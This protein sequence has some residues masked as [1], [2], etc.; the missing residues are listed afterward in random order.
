MLSRI[1]STR[2]HTANAT[3]TAM[4]L[5]GKFLLQRHRHLPRSCGGSFPTIVAASS[6]RAASD[7]AS[8]PLQAI[9]EMRV[10][11]AGFPVR[12][13]RIGCSD[14]A[15][16]PQRSTASA[17]S[18]LGIVRRSTRPPRRSDPADDCPAR[19]IAGRKA[20]FQAFVDLALAGLGLR[21]LRLSPPARRH[22][23]F[24]PLPCRGAWHRVTG[25]GS[26]GAATA[27]IQPRGWSG[28]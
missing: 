24:S 12:R 9:A 13:S 27:A 8:A 22:R 3:T 11:A 19:R 15:L 17:R 6:H 7:S 21:H 14:A 25:P 10:R 20:F 1:F 16:I 23:R 28:P 5:G 26:S 4:T 18:D 2:F